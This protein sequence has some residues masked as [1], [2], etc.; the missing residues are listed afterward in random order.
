VRFP[1][2][3]ASGGAAFANF[4]TSLPGK[5]VALFLMP[6]E[7]IPFFGYHGIVGIGIRSS[8]KSRHHALAHLVFLLWKLLPR[9]GARR[10]RRGEVACAVLL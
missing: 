9:L 7:A 6:M 2:L 3:R 8:L 10:R 4:A 1:A 5:V